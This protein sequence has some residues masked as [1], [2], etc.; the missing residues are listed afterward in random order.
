MEGC[1]EDIYGNIKIAYQRHCVRY[2]NHAVVVGCYGQKSEYHS[3]NAAVFYYVGVP[4][5]GILDEKS[6]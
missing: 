1:F 5:L 3:P 4:F 2:G 6:L